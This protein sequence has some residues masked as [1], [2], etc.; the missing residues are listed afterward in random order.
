[1]LY[2]KRIDFSEEIML[3]K[4]VNQKSAIFVTIGIFQGN[5]LIFNHMYAKLMQNI[6][7]IGKSG[8]YIHEKLLPHIKIAKEILTFGYTEIEK[9]N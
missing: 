5:D 2:F 9:K 7:L 6:N 4:Q 8:T 3:I 1:M